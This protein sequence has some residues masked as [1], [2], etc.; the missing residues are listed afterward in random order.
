MD[1][2]NSDFQSRIHTSFPAQV[3]AY[4]LGEQTVDVRPAI[5]RAYDTDDPAE[6][7]ELEPLPDI[8]S[9]P[10]LW[11][12]AGGFAITFPIAVGDWVKID[13]AEESLLKW[14][15]TGQTR[16]HPGLVDPHGLNG[17]VATPGWVP[18]TL[19]LTGVSASDFVIQGAGASIH[20]TP[21]PGGQVI[22]GATTGADYVAL[23]GLVS[24][25][26]TAAITGHTHTVPSGGGTS[27]NGA[28][29]G[30]VPSSA[31]SKVKAV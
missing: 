25:A 11:P 13:C 1:R 7:F 6:P 23:A 14:R 12:R 15:T 24:A 17:C 22:L 16:E 21:G 28:L 27:G 19:R 31:A 10:I 29:V 5:K 9:V 8:Y 4:D 26:I 3:L 30:S 20:I 18:D 2:V